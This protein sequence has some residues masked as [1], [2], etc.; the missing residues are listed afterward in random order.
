M[1]YYQAVKLIQCEQKVSI[2]AY[3][4]QTS[5]R[6]R[7]IATTAPEDVPLHKHK[8]NLTETETETEGQH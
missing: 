1:N 6:H 5:Y 3:A 2:H 7:N 4:R 8:G